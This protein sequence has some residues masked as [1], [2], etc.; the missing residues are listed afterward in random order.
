MWISNIIFT[1]EP[2]IKS[3]RKLES[4]ISALDFA[5]DVNWIPFLLPRI[6]KLVPVTQHAILDQVIDEE[7]KHFSQLS[8]IKKRYSA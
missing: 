5:F 1:K 7:R 3:W 2:W 8:E 4:T 6:K